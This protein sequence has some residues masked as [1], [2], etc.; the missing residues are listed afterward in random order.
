MSLKFLITSQTVAKF[1]VTQSSSHL[2][3]LYFPTNLD[4]FRHQQFSCFG[5]SNHFLCWQ[6]ADISI[7]N[8]TH[9]RCIDSFKP[10]VQFNLWPAAVQILPAHSWNVISLLQPVRVLNPQL[11]FSAHWRLIS[12]RQLQSEIISWIRQWAGSSLIH[13]SQSITSRVTT[14]PSRS[15]VQPYATPLAAPRSSI[16]GGV[17]GGRVSATLPFLGGESAGTT[18]AAHRLARNPRTGQV[19]QRLPSRLLWPKSETN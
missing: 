4:N 2:N 10:A 15:L 18:L 16:L 8:C 13:G 6:E 17:L 5:S 11:F 7:Y 14:S 3:F 9:Q 19:A 1:N 12:L